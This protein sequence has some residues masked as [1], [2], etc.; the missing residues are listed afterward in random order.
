MQPVM[1]SL[2]PKLKSAEILSGSLTNM[3]LVGTSSG[4]VCSGSPQ[5]IPPM[6]VQIRLNAHGGN[7]RFAF[8]SRSV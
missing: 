2:L 5:K 7:L 1:V 6:Q 8:A 3:Q 4:A